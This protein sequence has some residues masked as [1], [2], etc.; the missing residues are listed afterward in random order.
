M[1]KNAPVNARTCKHLKKLLGESYEHARLSMMTGRVSD[2]VAV[3]STSTEP[4]FSVFEPVK[5][6]QGRVSCLDPAR[7]EP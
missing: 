4:D 7:F 2:D 6:R 3:A 1:Q 5:R